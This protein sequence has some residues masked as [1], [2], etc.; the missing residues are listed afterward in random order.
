MSVSVR[1]G[2][3]AAGLAVAALAGSAASASAAYTV[4]AFYNPPASLPAANGTLIKSEPMSLGG[5]LNAKGT[6]LMYKSTDENGLPAA[7]TGTYLEPTRPWTG[8][9][10]R[11]LVSYAEGTQGQGDACAPSRT[12]Q[13]TLVLDQG[14]AAV[15]YEVLGIGGF[16]D[17]GI[18]VVVTDYIG[19]GTPDRVHSYTDRLDMGRAVLD[20]ARAAKQLPVAAITGSTPIGLYG[21]SQGGGASA[22]AAELAPSYA[23][24]LN[25]KGAFAGAPPADLFATLKQ[26]DGTSLTGV[27]GYAINGL[28]QYRPELKA[29]LDAETNDKGKAA[30]AKA[31]DQCIGDSL[32]SFA[33]QK[34]NAWTVSGKPAWQVVEGIPS[35]MQ[36]IDEQRIGKLKPSI[37]VQVLTG[38]KDDIVPHAQAKQLALDWCAKG[39]DV[40]Y[41]P[42]NQIFGSG[43]TSLNHLGPMLTNKDSSQA[44]LI[45]QLKGQGAA[46]NCAKVSSMP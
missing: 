39:A 40:N 6:R 12:L 3:Y 41:V 5:G 43:G 2:A 21:Y 37:P 20:A 27:L 18:P 10:P 22:S 13:S 28:V 38:T 16:L 46:G 7:V 1:L 42:V 31:A 25:L 34:T 17:K 44:W 4:P 24:D 15:G 11:P 30:L 26:A 9:G 32:L 35:A 19:L 36:A 45:N 14:Q 23:P 29:T 8:S 33:F